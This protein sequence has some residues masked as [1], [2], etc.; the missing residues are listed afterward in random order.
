MTQALRVC[1]KRSVR[2]DELLVARLL[3][4]GE[5]PAG[6]HEAIVVLTDP[7][8]DLLDKLS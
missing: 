1:V 5:V 4:D 2:D 7:T 3:E 8:Q 6:Y